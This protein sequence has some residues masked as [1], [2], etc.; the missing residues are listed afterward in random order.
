MGEDDV[1]RP[2]L[3]AGASWSYVLEAN[4]P[5][6]VARDAAHT[7]LTELQDTHRVDTAEEVRGLVALAVSDLV[8]NAYKYAPGPARLTLEADPP[9][10]Q[11]S[12]SDTGSLLPAPR[13][14]DPERVGQHGKGSRRSRGGARCE[15]WAQRTAAGRGDAGAGA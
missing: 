14:S 10:A 2:G 13:A 7:F 11:I 8:T 5:V 4:A 12:V 6:G 1:P 9:V 3:A 15:G